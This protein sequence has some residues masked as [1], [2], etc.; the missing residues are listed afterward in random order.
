[1]TNLQFSVRFKSSWRP[2]VSFRLG[3]LLGLNF[4]VLGLNFGVLGLGFKVLGLGLGVLGSASSV[5]FFGCKILAKVLGQTLSYLVKN[6]SSRSSFISDKR[7]PF[8]VL[9]F[10]VLGQH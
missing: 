1:M 3:E 2:A 8:N 5:Q 9:G 10:K 4:K 6:L 7:L